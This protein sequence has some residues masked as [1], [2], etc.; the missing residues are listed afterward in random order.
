DTRKDVTGNRIVLIAEKDSNM[1]DEALKNVEQIA[2]GNPESVPAGQYAQ[3]TLKSLNL[4]N[5]YKDK[6]ILGKDVRQVL[7][8]VDTGNTDIGFVYESDALSSDKVKILKKVSA[9][10]HDPIRYPAAVMADT[11]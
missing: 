6:L 3:Q 8:Y 11:K 2:I 1:R 7:T 10:T 5:K 4:W 9:D